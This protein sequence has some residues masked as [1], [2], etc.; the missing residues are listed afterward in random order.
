MERQLCDTAGAGGQPRKPGR[1]ATGGAGR[2]Q[3]AHCSR[4]TRCGIRCSRSSRGRQFWQAHCCGRTGFVEVRLNGGPVVGHRS[5]HLQQLQGRGALSTLSWHYNAL[6]VQLPL[7]P[8][9]PPCQ[10]QPQA[11]PASTPARSPAPQLLY[12]R[13]AAAGSGVCTHQT[14]RCPTKPSSKTS[15]EPPQKDHQ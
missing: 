11:R 6:R 2:R 3:A 15:H 13:A 10:F 5:V 9:T 8:P 1:Q 4:A 7:A 14:N 12:R